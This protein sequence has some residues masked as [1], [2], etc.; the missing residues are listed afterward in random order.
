MIYHLGFLLRRRLVLGRFV[1]PVRKAFSL[2]RSS[3]PGHA[4]AASVA[5]RSIGDVRGDGRSG[6]FSEFQMSF[7]TGG[8]NGNKKIGVRKGKKMVV[9]KGKK[10]V[11]KMGKT[12]RRRRKKQ[13]IRWNAPPKNFLKYNVDGASKLCIAG[14]IFATGAV[15][16]NCLGSLLK[17]FSYR[18]SNKEANGVASSSEV[19]FMALK[20]AVKQAIEDHLN[21]DRVIF[22]SDSKDV[23]KT[24]ERASKGKA[25]S[26]GPFIQSVVAEIMGLKPQGLKKFRIRH[27]LREGNRYADY[28]ANEGLTINQAGH[29]E[30]PPPKVRKEDIWEAHIF[31]NDLK[32]V[33]TERGKAKRGKKSRKSN[34]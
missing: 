21:L 25:I 32:G 11:F 20:M 16:R 22:E 5:P 8:Q 6:L 15:L 27:V 33:P 13:F 2:V 19:E 17:K 24:M 4:S 7:S 14:N 34:R 18:L 9:M 12:A 10:V 3:Q 30:I 29:K 28:M 1:S 31:R 23:V 26:R